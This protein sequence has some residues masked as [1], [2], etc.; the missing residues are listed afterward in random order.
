[1]SRDRRQRTDSR[2]SAVVVVAPWTV[3]NDATDGR[4]MVDTT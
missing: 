3:L 2:E 4:V 1:M